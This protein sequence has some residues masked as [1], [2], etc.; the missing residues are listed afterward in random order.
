MTD[1]P[2]FKIREAHGIGRLESPAEDDRQFAEFEDAE[3]AAIEASIDD[4]VWAVWENK[5]GEVL[6]VIYQRIAY[7]P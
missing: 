3:I 6:S 2:R 5:T 4:G 1:L 7:R